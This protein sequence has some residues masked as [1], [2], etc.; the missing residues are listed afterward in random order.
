MAV[1][2]YSSTTDLANYMHAVI[3]T[4]SASLGWTVGGNSYNEA[5]HDTLIALEVETVAEVTNTAALRAAARYFVW[6]AVADASAG[7]IR[8]SLD[9]QSFDM[10]AIHKHAVARQEQA[11]SEA[12]SLGVSLASIGVVTITPIRDAHDPYRYLPDD[13]RVLAG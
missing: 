13:V 7:F 9:Q 1:V 3:G 4:A 2:T 5:V 12:A 6:R 11:E 10:A 8:F